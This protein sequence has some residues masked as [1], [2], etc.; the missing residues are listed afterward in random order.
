MKIAVLLYY[1]S[2]MDGYVSSMGPHKRVADVKNT[3]M[4]NVGLS[5]ATKNLMFGHL[6]PDANPNSRPVFQKLVVLSM[7]GSS[8]GCGTNIHRTP[9]TWVTTLEHWLAP[10]HPGVPQHLCQSVVAT[11]TIARHGLLPP[12]RLDFR[13]QQ[14]SLLGFRALKFAL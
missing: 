12:P 8:V 9:L 13:L 6:P 10:V 3:H 14:L 4:Q 2:V 11:C 7:K 1:V 5:Q